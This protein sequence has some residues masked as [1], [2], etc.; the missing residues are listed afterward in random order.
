[1]REPPLPVEIRSRNDEVACTAAHL[2]SARAFV[3][4]RV[5]SIAASG[6][7]FRNA[8]VV[9]V[10]RHREIAVNCDR[11]CG[12]N[13]RWSRVEDEQRDEVAVLTKDSMG[14]CEKRRRGCECHVGGEGEKHLSTRHVARV[15][16]YKM[17]TNLLTPCM[18]RTSVGGS[19]SRARSTAGGIGSSDRCIVHVPL[20]PLAPF[21]TAPAQTAPSTS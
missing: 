1:M 14:D 2:P 12:G 4:S 6:V 7:V 21:H 5:R 18:S 8:I 19:A 20:P 16:R 17:I 3:T 15:L 9:V 11:F 13:A 10:Q